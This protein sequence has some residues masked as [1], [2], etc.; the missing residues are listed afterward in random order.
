M[1]TKF[2]IL[3]CVHLFVISAFSQ[4]EKPLNNQYMIINH[5]ILDLH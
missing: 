5:I 2:Y 3:L 1:N 4:E